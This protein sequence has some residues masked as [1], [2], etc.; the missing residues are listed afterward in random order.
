V[1]V[2]DLEQKHATNRITVLSYG[3]MRSGKTRFAASF[4]RPLFLSDATES[5]WTTI[6]NMDKQALY[7][8]DRLPKVWSIEAAKDMMQAIRDAES[9]IKNKPGE[10][11]TIVVDSLTFYADLFFNHI[12][13]ASSGRTDQRQLYMKLAQ[14]LR[15]LRIQL[16]TLPV[17]IVWLCLEKAPGEDTPVG[18]PMLSGQ[19]AQKFAAGCDYILF[20]RSFQI[21]PTSPVQWEIR[22]KRWNNYQAGGRDEGLLPDPLGYWAQSENGNDAFYADCTYRT[23]AEALNLNDPLSAFVS[24]NANGKAKTNI[25]TPTTNQTSATSGRANVTR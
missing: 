10:V 4:P 19:N 23:F 1:K 11:L 8:P 7:E 9:I 14:H 22:T 21:N 20:H 6:S 15:D 18:G 25:S 24:A 3:A 16:H 2:I 5:G 12:D 17:N 13:S